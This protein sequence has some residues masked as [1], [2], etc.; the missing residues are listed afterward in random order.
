MFKK[1]SDSWAWAVWAPSCR[2][3][4][5]HKVLQCC[6]SKQNSLVS[7]VWLA[8]DGNY[9]QANSPYYNPIISHS[10]PPS[11]SLVLCLVGP[12]GKLSFGC[13]TIILKQF[14][15]VVW[16]QRFIFPLL[17]WRTSIFHDLLIT[18][19]F[20]IYSL[21]CDTVHSAGQ[22]IKYHPLWLIGS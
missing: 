9:S 15:R 18:E 10:L 12:Y 1:K 22:S 14:A 2:V 21:V 4:V 8:S 16:T 11:I 5:Q 3:S 20:R 13:K 7:W 17:Q 19:A 6:R